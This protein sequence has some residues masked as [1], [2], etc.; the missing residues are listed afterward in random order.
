MANYYFKTP[1]K[2]IKKVGLM[3]SA[4]IA[5]MDRIQKDSEK[6]NEDYLF[7]YWYNKKS[8]TASN[9]HQKSS[10]NPEA[11]FIM[12]H[13]FG[14]ASYLHSAENRIFNSYYD[15]TLQTLSFLSKN[16]QLKSYI[17]IHP[18]SESFY[19]TQDKHLIKFFDDK[20][21]KFENIN[22]LYPKSSELPNIS[23]F[24]VTYQGSIAYEMSKIGIKTMV[25]NPHF[26]L[27]KNEAL[28]IP[29]DKV[30]YFKILK[31]FRKYNINID[32]ESRQE[33]DEYNKKVENTIT[34][35]WS[36]G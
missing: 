7:P 13:C 14:D 12:L 30:D 26:C 5:N 8:V 20:F 2:Y 29:K 23:S 1:V 11:I 18:D 19:K 15:W 25:V 4:H 24:I 21:S 6:L 27:A 16:N 33:L 36:S 17:R 31:N 34:N 9:F 28:I 3:N 32:E 22:F 10:K 35:Y